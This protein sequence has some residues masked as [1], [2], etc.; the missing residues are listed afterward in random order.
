M[1][2]LNDIFKGKQSEFPTSGYVETN[3]EENSIKFT[4]QEGPIKENKVNGCQ[5]DAMIWATAT[6]LRSFNSRF[7]CRENSCAITHL[8]EALMWLEKRK[9]DREAREVEGTNKK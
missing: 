5:I 9:K 8:D 3:P 7:P 4:I 6:I 1:S 2:E